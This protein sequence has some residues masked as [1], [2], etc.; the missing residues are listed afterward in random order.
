M[1]KVIQWLDQKTRDRGEWDQ[2][3]LEVGPCK[4]ALQGHVKKGILYV[5][6]MN[7]PTPRNSEKEHDSNG[8]RLDHCAKVSW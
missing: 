6:L 1:F 8:S 4:H 5:K 7:Q 2:Q 3:N